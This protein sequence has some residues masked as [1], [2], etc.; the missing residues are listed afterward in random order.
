MKPLE[1]PLDRLFHAASAAPRP[2]PAP[3]AF[4]LEARV[5][6]A[7]RSSRGTVPDWDMAVLVRGL[8]FAGLLMAVSIWP[9]LDRNPNADS[10]T[11]Q[12]AD[13]TVQTD[14]SP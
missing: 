14:L 12:F 1:T 5:L 13:S 9:A 2:L 8:A 10:E 4:G 3:P 6:A 11:L 7:W